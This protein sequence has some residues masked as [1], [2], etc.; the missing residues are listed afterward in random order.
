MRCTRSALTSAPHQDSQSSEVTHSCPAAQPPVRRPQS[1]VWVVCSRSM[2]RRATPYLFLLVTLIAWPS[3]QRAAQ[4]AGHMAVQSSLSSLHTAPSLPW[5]SC[6][7]EIFNKLSSF[8]PAVYP[9]SGLQNFGIKSLPDHW[10]Y[11]HT[12][13][14]CR[15]V[16]YL[17]VSCHTCCSEVTFQTGDLQGAPCC[18]TLCFLNKP[19]FH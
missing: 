2:P 7:E 15:M 11:I 9:I 12:C 17:G 4:C 13:R 8:P 18:N 19:Q 3:P 14:R 6:L 16:S 10:V 1:G 5:A